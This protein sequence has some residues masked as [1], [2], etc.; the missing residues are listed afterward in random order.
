MSI[1]VNL[2]G[3]PGGGKSTGMAYIFSQL[4]LRGISCEQASEY[5]KDKIWEGHD[6]IQDY[7]IYVFAKQLKKIQSLNNKVDV[8]ITDSPLFLQ[9]YYGKNEGENFKNLVIEKFNSFNNKNYFINRVKKY[10]PKGRYQTEI[11]S[12]A[13]ADNL[14]NLLEEHN[15]NYSIMDGNTNGYDLIVDEIVEIVNLKNI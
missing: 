3:Q 14:K 15:I 5:I 13:I 11:E 10:D 6:H 2:I 8:I 9:M 4:K 1:V 12:D 7:Q